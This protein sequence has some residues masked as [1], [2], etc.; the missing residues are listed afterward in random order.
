MSRPFLLPDG[1]DVPIWGQRSPAGPG[2]QPTVA[3]ATAPVTA[4]DSD[5]WAGSSYRGACFGCLWLGPERDSENAG[6]EDAH[7]HTHPGWWALPVIAPYRY[8]DEKARQRLALHLASLYP[9]DWA[10]R[11]G[12]TVT[13]R[14]PIGSRHVPG[15]G[16]FGGY[17]MARVKA[18]AGVAPAVAEA[19]QLALSL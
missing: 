9:Q 15:G 3:V 12:P 5:R 6:A 13:W 18:V 19:A 17:C 10:S 11:A 8:D 1:W 4:A 14:N 16:L 7:D 2:C